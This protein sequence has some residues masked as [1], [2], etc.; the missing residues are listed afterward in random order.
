MVNS[1]KESQK[2]NGRRGTEDCACVLNGENAD[3]RGGELLLLAV[4]DH[5]SSNDGGDD[6]QQEH[7]KTETDPSLLAGSSSGHYRLIRVLDPG[8][9]RQQRRGDVPRMTY[10]LEASCSMSWAVFWM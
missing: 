10:P 2:H 1:R 4:R 8:G 3:R 9:R 7:E 5:N 6:G